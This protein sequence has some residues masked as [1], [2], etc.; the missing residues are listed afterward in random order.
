MP[1]RLRKQ[2]NHQKLWALSQ[3]QSAGVDVRRR[4]PVSFNQTGAYH[5]IVKDSCVCFPYGALILH[6]DA[7]ETVDGDAYTVLLQIK[8]SIYNKN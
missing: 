6:L 3:I 1:V 4:A 2:Y 5:A 7:F 8:R